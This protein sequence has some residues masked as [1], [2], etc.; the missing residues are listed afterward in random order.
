MQLL[1][2][3]KPMEDLEIKNRVAGSSLI[4]LDLEDYYHQ[5]PRMQMDMADW[6]WERMMLREKDFRERVVAHDWSQYAGANVAIIC[7]EDAIVPVWAYMLLVTRLAP[8]A[9]HVVIGD[10]AELDNDLFRAALRG[11]DPAKY[12]SAKIVVKGCSKHPVPTA[13][14][15]EITRLLAPVVSSLM[16]GEACSAVPLYKRPKGQ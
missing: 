11:I 1:S 9:H 6:L 7:S 8:Y 16:Y 10:M 13:A 15:V 14:Y 3:C 2:D 4:T 5:G 12:A